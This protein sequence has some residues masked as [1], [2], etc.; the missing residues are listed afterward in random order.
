MAAWRRRRRLRR[1]TA[2]L[3]L[4]GGPPAAVAAPQRRGARRPGEEAQGQVG[5]PKSYA[6]TGVVFWDLDNKVPAKGV[7][8]RACVEALRLTLLKDCRDVEAVRLYANTITLSYAYGAVMPQSSRVQEEEEEEQEKKALVP[9]LVCPVCGK[10]LKGKIWTRRRKLRRHF[11]LHA[12]E[13]KKRD[14][15][16]SCLGRN[17]RGGQRESF[18]HKNFAFLKGREV[19]KELLGSIHGLVLKES[20]KATCRQIR[21]IGGTSISPV[22]AVPQAADEELVYDLLTLARSE[23]GVAGPGTICLISDDGGYMKPLRIVR[24]M[25]WRVVVISNREAMLNCGDRSLEWSELMVD[26][27]SVRRAPRGAKPDVFFN[28]PYRDD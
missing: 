7:S 6:G 14:L 15:L 19:I 13:Y 8:I 22:P 25:G 21:E 4:R 18:I 9:P 17:I 20:A 2:R 24:N 11:E 1:L 28:N 12:E 16:R 23:A 5:T 26:A 27:A 3:A 10:P